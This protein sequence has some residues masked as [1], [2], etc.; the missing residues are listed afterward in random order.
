MDKQDQ[1]ENLWN[2]LENLMSSQALGVL[3]THDHGQPYTSLVAFVCSQ[4][5]KQLFFVTGKTTRK[6]AN[7]KSDPRA[8]LLIDSRSNTPLDIADAMAATATGSVEMVSGDDLVKLKALYLKK[9]P[10]LIDF[11]ESPSTQLIKLNVSCYY[12]VNRFQNVVELHM[13]KE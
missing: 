11:A 2:S 3:A 4:D 7:L 1:R 13:R 12:M 6:Y 8:A 10:H 5:L 9:H